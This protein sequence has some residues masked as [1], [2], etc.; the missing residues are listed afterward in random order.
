MFLRNEQKLKCTNKCRCLGF[1][2]LFS[3]CAQRDTVLRIHVMRYS[4]QTPNA[5]YEDLTL[6][7]FVSKVCLPLHK[8][9]TTSSLKRAIPQL[10]HQI[11]DTHNRVRLVLEMKQTNLVCHSFLSTSKVLTVANCNLFQA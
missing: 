8:D 11:Y 10:L 5:V 2:L 9:G 7:E 1:D 4:P 6:S 3:T